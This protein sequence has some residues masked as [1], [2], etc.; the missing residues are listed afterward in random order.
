MQRGWRRGPPESENPRGRHRPPAKL[1]LSD[2]V[3]LWYE[4]PGPAVR[5]VVPV[6]AHDEVVALGDHLRP[7][8]VMAPVLLRHVIVVQR[9]LVDVHLAVDDP[10]RVAFFR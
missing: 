2:D 1:N 9:D 8:V 6:I 3:P 10:H 7:P 4:A 5:A